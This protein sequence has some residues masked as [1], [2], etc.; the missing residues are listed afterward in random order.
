M[1][2]HQ[3]DDELFEVAATVEM[4]ED[5]T[6]EQK[7][8]DSPD[9]S[10]SEKAAADVSNE[11]ADAAA[12]VEAVEKNAATSDEGSDIYSEEAKEED[13]LQAQ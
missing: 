2:T 9:V 12:K 3:A 7:V 1:S 4:P 13:Q 5:E 8:E 11:I 6:Q 10:R